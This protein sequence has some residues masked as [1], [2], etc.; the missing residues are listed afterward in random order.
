MTDD[1]VTE[2]FIAIAHE[3]CRREDRLAKSANKVLICDTDPFATSIWHERYLKKRSPEV[4]SIA[5][6][7]KYDLYIVTGDEIPFVQDGIR[8][9]KHIRHRM[10]ARFIE[11][12]DQT[13]RRRVL[14]TGNPSER[15]SSA[16]RC[17][18]KILSTAPH[19]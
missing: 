6:S 16:A 7:R 5:Q 13:Q 15:L 17:I 3:Q 12:L 9:G 19:K 8:D 1:W 14:I 11:A 2:E 10:H 18:N 4:E